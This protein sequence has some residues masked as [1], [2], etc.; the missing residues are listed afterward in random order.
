M[1]GRSLDWY[2][3]G[4]RFYEPEIGRWQ[5]IDPVAEKAYGW[6]PFRYGYDNP[7]SY[8]DSTGMS[9][10]WYEDENNNVVYDAAV[11]SQADLDSKGVQGTYLG[12]EGYG[13]NPSTGDAVH[14]K[15]DGTT[16][17]GSNGI[18]A[19]GVSAPMSDHARTMSNPEV[20]AI[21]KEQAEFIKTAVDV[22]V[23]SVEN[24]GDAI[25][26]AGYSLT[27]TGLGSEVGLPMVVLG[28][29]ISASGGLAEAGVAYLRG[30]KELAATKFITTMAGVGLSNPVL[31]SKGF[32]TIEKI[33]IN[34]WIDGPKTIIDKCLSKK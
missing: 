13:I 33:G 6:S 19:A 30:D 12:K 24:A 4:A 16:S 11:T 20:Q 7:I 18:E 8:V 27:A 22:T 25:S 32:S 1:A 17:E 14:Y 10:D 15:A 5:T 29:T 34:A 9:E 31:K 2:D 26:Y 21:H 23:A 3:Y 28:G